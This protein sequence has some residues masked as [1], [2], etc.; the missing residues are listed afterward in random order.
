MEELF[1]N[2]VQKVKDNKQ[3]LIKVGSALVGAVAG[4]LIAGAVTAEPEWAEMANPDDGA[5]PPAEE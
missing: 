3:T 5:A 1:K 4:A 2:V